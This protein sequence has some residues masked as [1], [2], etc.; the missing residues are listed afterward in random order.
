MLL[1]PVV[2]TLKLIVTP[3]GAQEFRKVATAANFAAARDD[4]K[5]PPA[6]YVIPARDTAGANKLGGGGA[7]IQ[8]V[9][10]QFGVVLAVSN[11]RDA[12]GVAAQVEFERLR[13]LVI[14]QMLG[15]VPG[16]GYE[17]CEYGGGALLALD[18]SVLWWQLVFRTGYTE[19]NY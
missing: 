19:R 2:D 8:P 15:F 7:I 14:D 17:P 3:G 13:R 6:A 9:A 10:E 18:A 5:T 11:L 16:D 12:S 4:L 1:A